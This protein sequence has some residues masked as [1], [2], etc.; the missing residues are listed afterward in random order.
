MKKHL[1]IPIL[2]A[3]LLCALAACPAPGM[4]GDFTPAQMKKMG[5][6]LSNF[7][8]LSFYNVDVR[9]FV[10]PLHPEKAIRFGIWH[11]YVNNFRSRCGH[12]DPSCPYGSLVMDAKY[13]TESVEKYL[14]FGFTR[15]QSVQTDF[16]TAHYD[17]HRYHFEGAD[18]ERVLYARVREATRI[19]KGIIRLRGILYDTEEPSEQKGT[20]TAEIT[21]DTWK[22]KESWHLLNLSCILN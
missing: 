20:F 21:P 7:T 17:G 18:G 6:F 5:I 1:F 16:I 11:N 3:F 8:E 4:A 22:G 15:H 12:C 2:C 19:T 13:V 10:D 14:G 9:D